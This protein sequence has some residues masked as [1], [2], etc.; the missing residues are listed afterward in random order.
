MKQE[1]ISYEEIRSTKEIEYG[2]AFKDWIWIL[3]KQYRDRTHFL[4]ELLQNAE[5]AKAEKIHLCLS[6]EMLV[7]EHDGILFSRADV[8]SITKVAKS[9]KET[10]GGN[11]GRFGIGFKSVYAYTTSP[12]IY[13]GNY[14]FEIHDFIFPYEIAPMKLRDG[15]TRIEIPFNNPEISA[16]KAYGEIKQA[17][18]EQIGTDSLLFLNNIDEIVIS[19]GGSSG[20]ILITK[21]EKERDDGY[22]NVLDV[23]MKYKSTYIEKSEDYLL[24]TDCEEEAI[25]L[26]FLISE[27]QLMPVNNTRIYTFFPTDKESHQAFYIHAPFMTTPARDNIV[28]DSEK[29]SQFIESICEGMNMAFCWMRDRN[30]LTLSGLNAVY[31]TYEYPKETILY[32]IYTNAINLLKSGER[33][34]PINRPGVY[35]NVQEV[36]FPE[37]M[38][39]AECFD[40]NDI[41]WLLHNQQIFWIAKEINRESFQALRSFLRNNIEFSQYSWKDLIGRLDARFLRQKQK[42]WFAHLFDSIRSFASL[43]PRIGAKHEVDISDIPFVRLSNGEQITAYVDG[44]PSVYINNPD[45]CANKIDPS[46]LDEPAIREFYSSNL[47]IPEYNV[48]RIVLDEVLEKYR[49][50][51][52]VTVSFRENV[53]DL[54]LIKDALQKAPYILNSVQE[55]YILTD[56]SSWYKPQELHIP[57]GY[58]GRNIQSYKLLSGICRIDCITLDYEQELKLDD[59]FFLTLGCADGLMKR[60]IDQKNYLRYVEA[61]QGKEASTELRRRIFDKA[62]QGG[63]QWNI[64]YEGFPDVFEK[65][66]FRR[67][68]ALAGFLNSKATSI[69]I[70]GELTGANDRDFCGANVDTMPAYSAL[71]LMICFSPWLYTKTGEAKAPV[72]IHRRDLDEAYE[73]EARRFLDKLPFREEDRAVEEIL[74][75]YENAQDRETLRKVLT[76]S[77][78]LPMITKALQE[79]ELKEKRRLEKRN[80]SPEQLLEEQAVRKA[81]NSSQPGILDD[82]TPEAVSNPERRREKLEK[83]FEQSLDF[84]TNVAQTKLKFT[85]QDEVT[86]EEKKFL[87]MQ[88]HG[89]CQIC[90][91]RIQKVDGTPHFHAINV[92]KTSNLSQ[93]YRDSLNLGWNSLCL[94]PNCAAKYQYGEK[95]LTQFSKQV[96]EKSVIAKDESYLHIRIA[97]Q[98]EEVEIRYTPK[99]FLALKTAFEVFIKA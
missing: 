53:A 55:V 87:E 30:Y 47:S 92:L 65:M 77:D 98:G 81:S 70:K 46:F 13:S 9:T 8:I 25:K 11:I 61:Y 16:E 95:D 90:H 51:N 75:R 50:R 24:F 23:S 15:I 31:P 48:E 29:N 34:I 28:E 1:P 54:K 38:V 14:S 10:S 33:L 66:D 19:V 45:A 62:Y 42:S 52:N 35:K 64:V 6:K 37:N 80:K 32:E 60:E 44:R 82:D 40:D 4:F 88:Y 17:L 74:N 21:T 3:V 67:S 69:D 93:E 89:I 99:H 78:M 43:R 5:D 63:L 57:S 49:S 85:Y 22:G 59:K 71:G 56:G 12:R 27:G 96:R 18:Y 20:D 97:L 7:I 76:K 73:K 36:V 84:F 68:R 2:T 41:Q 94:C 86:P 83:E 91:T 72:H 39:I 79:K 26:A 58:S